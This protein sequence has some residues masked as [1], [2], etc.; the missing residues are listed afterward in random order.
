MFSLFPGTDTNSPRNELIVARPIKFSIMGR[1]DLLKVL[2]HLLKVYIF[3][4]YTFIKGI[5]NGLHYDFKVF[6]SL[7]TS[8]VECFMILC[9]G[10]VE[11]VLEVNS[12]S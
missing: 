6:Q 7:K 8:T 2:L 1:I 12:F 3:M 11:V 9:Q 10:S 5:S 4:F